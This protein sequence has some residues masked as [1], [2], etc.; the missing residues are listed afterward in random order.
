VQ[1]AIDPKATT[2]LLRLPALAG[3][4]SKV[5]GFVTHISSGP[6]VQIVSLSAI[7]KRIGFREGFSNRDS[8]VVCSGHS[9]TRLGE[10]VRRCPLSDVDTFI[11]HSAEAGPLSSPLE[12]FP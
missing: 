7:R 12:K 5:H 11:D 1:L 10:D 2:R 4:G 9:L 3:G 8:G 6:M